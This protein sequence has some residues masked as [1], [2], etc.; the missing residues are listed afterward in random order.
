MTR[1]AAFDCGTNSLR[2][3]I[4]DIERDGTV[5]DVVRTREFV[6]LGEGVDSTGRFS[7]EALRRTIE[8]TREYAA[9]CEQHG[10]ERK[11]F[12]AT[13]ATRDA[14]NRDEFIG[15]VREILGI[16]PEVVAG[17]EE[18]ALSFRGALSVLGTASGADAA[19]D[20]RRLIVDIGGG[21]T[22]LVVGRE[23]PESAYSMDVGCVR[24]TERNIRE[25]PPSPDELEGVRR[26]TSAA[27]DKAS[28]VVDLGSA[29][30]IVGVAGT[31][32]T[33]TAH[34]LGLERYDA[35]VLNGAKLSLQQVL[36]ACE[37]LAAMPRAQRAALPYMHAG[38]VDVIP[39]GA[40]IW[41][42]VLQRVAEEVAKS[43]TQ[44]LPVVTSEHDILDGV[45][46]SLAE[47]G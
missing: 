33:I 35:G 27:L 30:E 31:I 41:S 44:L 4:A 17:T 18:A 28:Q 6:R 47:I 42:T 7:D 36:D 38:R 14:A 11:R 26:E 39:V 5:H 8:V 9:L 25:D 2:L 20:H 29:S 1:V 40:V 10:V 24:L 22:E 23:A 15:S 21:S 34:A 37:S 16:E 19:V 12:V 45:A 32:T 13:S 3:L 46:M 43:G